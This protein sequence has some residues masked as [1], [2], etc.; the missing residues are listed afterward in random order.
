M[1]RIS[2]KDVK[3]GDLLFLNSIEGYLIIE[4]TKAEPI[5]TH[6]RWVYGKYLNTTIQHLK[7]VYQGFVFLDDLIETYLLE[8]GDTEEIVA[9]YLI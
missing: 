5:K 4:I 2:W 6:Y 9:K 7:H 8:E 1:K 3:V